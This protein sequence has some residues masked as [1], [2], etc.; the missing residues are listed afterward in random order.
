MADLSIPARNSVAAQQELFARA[1]SDEGLSLAAIHALDK[2]LRM[3]TM[4]GW[5]SGATQMPAWAIGALGEVGVPDHL[6]SLVTAPWMRSVITDEETDSD[7]DDAADAAAD[8]VTAVRRA[9]HPQ[10]PGGVAIV[11]TETAQIKPLVRRAHA[12]LR[13]VA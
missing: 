10:S 13:R 3:S 2:H 4:R 11:H 12:K 1:A 5:A 7:L 9:R 8:V 6:L